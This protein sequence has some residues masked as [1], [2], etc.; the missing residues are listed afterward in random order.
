MN[1]DAV[2]SPKKLTVWPSFVCAMT[3][4]PAETASLKLA[5]LLL[6]NVNVATSA[7]AFSAVTTPKVPALNVTD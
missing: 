7:M 4:L 3:M 5:P 2:T 1:V 6:L